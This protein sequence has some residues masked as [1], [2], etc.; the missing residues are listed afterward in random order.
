MKQ[1]SYPHYCSERPTGRVKGGT[2][3][4]LSRFRL[5]KIDK[6]GGEGRPYKKT[7]LTHHPCTNLKSVCNIIGSRALRADQKKVLT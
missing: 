7:V 4:F 1:L 3:S 5:T 6:E 2:P